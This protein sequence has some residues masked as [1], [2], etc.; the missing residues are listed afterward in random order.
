MSNQQQVGIIHY[1]TLISAQ[2]AALDSEK[3]GLDIL[4]KRLV[5]SVNLMK[6]LGGG[7]QA[8]ELDAYATPVAKK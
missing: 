8:S 3:V 1:P 7:W 4:A 5:A 2:T 6:A